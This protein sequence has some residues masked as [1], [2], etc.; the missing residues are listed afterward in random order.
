[1]SYIYKITNLITNKSY[2][3]ETNRTIEIRWKQHKQ[4]A[5]DLN[6]TE[7]L[8]NSIRK[9]GI[10]N[11]TIEKLEE[12]SPEERF[13]RE[14]YYIMLFNTLAPNGYNLILS[15]NGCTND[16]INAMLELWKQGASI[17]KISTILHISSKTVGQCL[18][19]NGVSQEEIFARR[20]KNV[21]IYSSKTVIRYSLEGEYIGEWTSASEAGRQLNMN[22]SSISKSCNGDI[23]SYNGY[24]WQYKYSDDIENRILLIKAKKKT[25]VNKKSISCF[26]LQHN[27]IQVYESASAAG[28]ALNVA[29]SG[30][31]YAARNHTQAYNFYWEYNI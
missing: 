21:G 3:G 6:N 5:I 15:Q 14:T 8:Y 25:G 20:A 26:D 11:F 29:H 9:H 24:I 31:A 12:C 4:R 2:I 13:E 22:N 18:K 19:S 16:M 27:L 1:M 28:R 7:Y 23:L 10:E 30:I 17:V